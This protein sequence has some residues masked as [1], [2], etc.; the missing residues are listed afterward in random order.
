MFSIYICQNF[1]TI[2]KSC[3]DAAPMSWPQ[4]TLRP[5]VRVRVHQVNTKV[6]KFPFMSKLLF[7]S[8]PCTSSLSSLDI[9]LTNFIGK[10]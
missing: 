3:S 5:E 4:F 6:S 1:T 2:V 7:L 9:E 10:F 8:K